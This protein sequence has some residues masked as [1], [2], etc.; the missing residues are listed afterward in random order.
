M[1]PYG[2]DGGL[3]TLNRETHTEKFQIS[4]VETPFS[5]K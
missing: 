2:L 4:Y 5:R 3:N 1:S